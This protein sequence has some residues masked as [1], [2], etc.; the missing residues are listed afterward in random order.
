MNITIINTE[1][2][3][4]CQQ[5]WDEFLPP[6]HHLQSRHL[7]AFENAA[8]ENITTQYVQVFLKEE[9]IGLLYLQQFRF[10]HNHLNFN[11]RPALLS[12][13]IG[14][15]LPAQV[16]LL[17]C[18]H[19]FRI[20]FEGFYFK[21]PAH[22]PLLF[23]AIE[24][25]QQQNQYKPGGIIIKDCPGIFIEQRCQLSGYHF[26]NG[27]VTMEI[28]RKEPWLS[29]DD[30]LKSLKKDYRQRAKKIIQ[31]FE[32]IETKELNA[33]G[34][35][36]QAAAIDRLYWNVVNK[37]TVKLGTI[38][39]AYFYELK[40]D[41]QQNFEFHALYLDGIM[42]GFYTFIFYQHTMETHFIGLDYEVNKTSNL[43]F[44]ILFAG[45][46][47]MIGKKFD[48]LE[49]GRTGREAKGNAGAQPRQVFNYIKVNNLVVK[50]TINYFLKRFNKA[51]NYNLTE[52]SVFK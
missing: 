16:P 51:A 19:L 32:N 6:G 7:Q 4:A 17:V 14:V 33:A 21:D 8:V 41:L 49:L 22:Q 50:I 31:R 47:T 34:I 23:D 42:V 24:L 48:L 43:Y 26:F 52:R 35:K 15:L 28:S 45:I 27:D 13:L 46:R 2:V 20:N 5:S 25:F 9:L 10:Q 44:N 12:K 38:N 11:R 29:F 36:E 39:N 30:Y 3:A 1:Q 37:Q 18:G 40:K